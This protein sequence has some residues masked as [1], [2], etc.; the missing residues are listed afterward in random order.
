MEDWVW[1]GRYGGTKSGVSALFNPRQNWCQTMS[2]GSGLVSNF[3]GVCLGQFGSFLSI[4]P[5]EF[6]SSN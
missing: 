2:N 6:G 3:A 1:F 5:Y 4:G